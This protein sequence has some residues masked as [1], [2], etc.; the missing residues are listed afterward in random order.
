MRGPRPEATGTR[1][2]ARPRDLRGAVRRRTRTR[3]PRPASRA[4]TGPASRRRP[5][6][7]LA[8][9]TVFGPLRHAH[10]RDLLRRHV[11]E[12]FAPVLVHGLRQG[13]ERRELHGAEDRTRSGGDG[14]RA[15]YRSAEGEHLRRL[16]GEHDRRL[17]LRGVEPV[18]LRVEGRA[19][20]ADDLEAGEVGHEG[21]GGVAVRRRGRR[22][23]D[24]PAPLLP[25]HEIDLREI[26]TLERDGDDVVRLEVGEALRRPR[27]LLG[28]RLLA[29]EEDD[30][31]EKGEEDARQDEQLAGST[32]D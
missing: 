10:A 7:S 31:R 29:L 24:G 1:R 2:S 12:L 32:S 13:R 21:V 23:R 22:V 14:V 6:P 3:G 19:G 26:G 25:A 11:E 5:S 15:G 16:V 18:L 17:G 27:A 20:L 4:A 28:V 8:T 30:E 9:T